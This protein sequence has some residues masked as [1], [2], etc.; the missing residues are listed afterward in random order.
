MMKTTVFMNDLSYL[1]EINDQET[2]I[3]RVSKNASQKLE[4]VAFLKVL[5]WPSVCILQPDR[6]VS[7]SRYMILI[8]L[9]PVVQR[10]WSKLHFMN[11]G[12][13]FQSLV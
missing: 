1:A 2:S 7:F 12:K 10:T 13:H 8:D 11:F 5:K 9:L 4:H 6:L 3:F